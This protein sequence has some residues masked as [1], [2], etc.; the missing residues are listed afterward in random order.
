MSNIKDQLIEVLEK[1]VASDKTPAKIKEEAQALLDVL[2]PVVDPEPV[3]TPEPE[4]TP[5]PIPVPSKPVLRG[6][7]FYPHQIYGTAKTP[8]WSGNCG[9]DS[10]LGYVSI[11]GNSWEL[12]ARRNGYAWIKAM[13]GQAAV[14]IAEKL[15]GNRELA[16]FLTNCKHP[17][18][19]HRMNDKENEVIIARNNYGVNLWVVSLFNDDETSIPANKHEDYIK[20]IVGLYDWADKDQAVWLICLET[21][22]R[23][24]SVADVIQRVAWVRKY[25][26]DHR[27]IVGS[28]SV[29]FLLAVAAKD[30]S[31][32]LWLEQNAH[33]TQKPLTLTTATSYI[34]SL[35]K[36]AA[37]VGAGNTWAGEWWAKDIETRRK[38][39][40]L[41]VA[42]GYN[43]GSG[44]FAT[45]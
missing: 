17:E 33:P 23:F 10:L 38:I 6:V 27:V 42:K 45:T 31:I 25:S 2:R 34:E 19:G 36:L 8:V 16:M 26:P 5:E 3:P 40:K 11:H 21:D 35:D 29:D 44:D 4:P 18:D 30:A 41:I 39:T 28:A 9:V 7:M 22:E 12:E 32:E 37:K 13:G 43:C 1:I 24:P 14:I 15:Y 20:E